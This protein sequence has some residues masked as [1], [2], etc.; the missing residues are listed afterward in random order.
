MLEL[1][2]ISDMCSASKNRQ[3]RLQMM[4]DE[5]INATEQRGR[6]VDALQIELQAARVH[7]K[8]LE[9]EILKLTLELPIK[10]KEIERLKL[11]TKK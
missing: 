2:K 8:E 7:E 3:S 11:E 1:K 6:R 4:L 10:E 5:Q 9:Q